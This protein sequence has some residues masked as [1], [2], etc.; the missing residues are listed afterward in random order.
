MDRVRGFLYSVD[1][2]YDHAL[3]ALK[4]KK[5]ASFERCDCAEDPA[6]ALPGMNEGMAV[7]YRPSRF[8]RY[9]HKESHSGWECWRLLQ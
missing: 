8:G 9:Q 1:S 2:I 3:I 7:L 6:Y 5:P 4:G